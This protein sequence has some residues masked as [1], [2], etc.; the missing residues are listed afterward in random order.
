M[1]A[2]RQRTL[3]AFRPVACLFNLGWAGGWLAGGQTGWQDWR[4]GLWL[5]ERLA[6]Y[7]APSV[8]FSH[9]DGHPRR[10]GLGPGQP[11]C[12]CTEQV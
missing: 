9:H 3:R 8:P 4:A 1:Q 7:V 10:N 11:A 5:A 12:M 2:G 6:G